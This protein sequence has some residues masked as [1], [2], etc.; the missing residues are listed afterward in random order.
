MICS[1]SLL[2]QVGSQWWSSHLNELVLG[3]WLTFTSCHVCGCFLVVCLSLCRIDLVYL[4]L[5]CGDSCKGWVTIYIFNAGQIFLTMAWSQ[6]RTL[7]FQGRCHKTN[8]CFSKICAALEMINRVYYLWLF[9]GLWRFCW[10]ACILET[11]RGKVKPGCSVSITTLMDELVFVQESSNCTT[12]DPFKI[13]KRCRTWMAQ[14]LSF[15]SNHCKRPLW[16]RT[17]C[18]C[19]TLLTELILSEGHWRCT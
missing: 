18:R 2:F 6:S 12:T 11:W 1:A 3:V 9:P 5:F 19:D 7:T 8:S 17:L 15:K 4:V 16:T 14:A 10:T 13:F